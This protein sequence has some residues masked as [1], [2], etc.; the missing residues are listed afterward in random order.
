MVEWRESRAAILFDASQ[1]HSRSERWRFAS[2]LLLSSSD[3]ELRF[4]LGCAARAAAEAEA[5]RP[6]GLM[7]AF[8]IW[9][10]GLPSAQTTIMERDMIR[11][12]AFMS[13]RVLKRQQI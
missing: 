1:V 11:R 8:E 6:P 12:I 3:R 7:T 5:M 13:C 9:H 4:L 2:L 10:V